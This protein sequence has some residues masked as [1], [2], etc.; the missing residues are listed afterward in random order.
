MVPATVYGAYGFNTDHDQ[1]AF[2]SLPNVPREGFTDPSLLQEGNMARKKLKGTSEDTET[3][4]PSMSSVA[5]K[6]QL[7]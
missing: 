5:L 1:R 4:V 6:A 2:G 7:G 3:L